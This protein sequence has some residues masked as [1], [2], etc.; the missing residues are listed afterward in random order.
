LRAIR[1][2]RADAAVLSETSG[3]LSIGVPELPAAVRRLVG[4]GKAG[5][6]EKQKLREELAAFQGA[7]LV[8]EEP[9]ENGL[10]LMV[11]D[12]KDRD[13]DY[14]KLLAS[15]TAAAAEKTAVIFCA[16]E[17]HPWRVFVARSQGLNFDSGRILREALAQVG[18]RGG[19]S[20]DLAQGDVPREHEPALITT[21]AD[22]IRGL[23]N[24]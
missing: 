9:I 12:W 10:R 8:Q 5:A 14:V 1:A 11:R 20:P 21:L 13:R 6:K 4:E 3:L 16:K 7:K 23:M 24:S 19:G 17:S 22:T 2:A 15:R 18:L